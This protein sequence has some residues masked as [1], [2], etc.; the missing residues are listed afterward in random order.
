[1][2]PS[3]PLKIF[4]VTGEHSGDALGGK[5]MSALRGAL[6]GREISFAGLGGAAMEAEGF[7]S[8]FPLDDVIV[9]GPLAIARDYP[10]LR[11]R[12]FE[13]IDAAV[14]SEPDAL[15]IIDAPELTH[16]IAKR[17]RKQR[18]DLPVINYVSPSVWA[19]RPGRAKKMRRYI[20]HV[21]ALLPFEPAVHEQLGGPECT[22]VGHPLV[23][24][25][26]SIDTLDTHAFAT[27]LGLQPNR[28]RLVV[29]PGS[30]TSEVSRLLRP[31]GE[32]VADLAKRVD[33]EVLV[34]AVPR[35][36]ETIENAVQSWPA[37]TYVLDGDDDKWSALKLADAALA[38]SG[39]VTLEVA[40]SGTPMVVGYK[41]DLLAWQLRF[42]MTAPSIV[43]ANLVLDE[44]AF[45]EFIQH[46]CEAADLTP[47]VEALLTE[48][49]ERARQV[50]ALA[51][52]RN[53][54]EL[55]GQRPSEK[56]AA[57]IRDVLQAT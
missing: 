53:R 17:V 11:R 38:A 52:I 45:P 3:T 7:A 55:D 57:V 27:R 31:F 24:R 9:M 26:A 30:R 14:S 5:L 49:P 54:M 50:M 15:I 48:T 44:N 25:L 32:T 56:A 8:L 22:Y 35:Q 43:L 33:L 1:M 18:A 41:V 10:R 13:V 29:L 37:P 46:R 6:P 34:P 4:I 47:A 2:A 21:L 51:K 16:P 42:L 23:E 12:A 39:T 36:K 40:V 20:D 19:W 28:K